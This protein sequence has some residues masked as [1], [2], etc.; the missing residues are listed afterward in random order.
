[1][2]RLLHL[3]M[4]VSLMFIKNQ[5][6]Y[7]IAQFNV[8]EAFSSN[9]GNICIEQGCFVSDSALLIT[10]KSL[11]SAE[12]EKFHD[13]KLALN[14]AVSALIFFGTELN[15][16]CFSWSQSSICFKL[17]IFQ[18]S[19]EWPLNRGR[20]LLILVR[21]LLLVKRSTTVVAFF[22][23]FRMLKELIPN[24]SYFKRLG[25]IDSLDETNCTFAPKVTELKKVHDGCVFYSSYV[26]VGKMKGFR[27]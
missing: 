6:Y 11:N 10:R 18:E 1:M 5:G 23:V 2:T 14:S 3:N 4:V 8:S 22:P 7:V 13:R 9:L 12:N 27:R 16:A 26:P 19:F 21:A 24:W 20:K 15:S 17:S 25:K